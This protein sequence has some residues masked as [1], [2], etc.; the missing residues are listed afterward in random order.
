MVREKEAAILET[1]TAVEVGLGGPGSEYPLVQQVPTERDRQSG[2]VTLGALIWNSRFFSD[3]RFLQ[4]LKYPLRLRA[5]WNPGLTSGTK[6]GHQWKNPRI[7]NE[8]CS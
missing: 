4:K 3:L 8:V 5:T 1:G 7:P 6:E 2:Y